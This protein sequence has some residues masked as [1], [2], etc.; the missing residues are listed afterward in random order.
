MLEGDFHPEQIVYGRDI[1]RARPEGMLGEP[2]PIQPRG[3]FPTEGGE[4]IQVGMGSMEGMIEKAKG[5]GYGSQRALKNR[6][7]KE[8]KKLEDYDLVKG[9]DGWRG[10]PKKKD[11]VVDIS[12]YG[13]YGDIA[14]RK[15][16]V[17][18]NIFREYDDVAAVRDTD[19]MLHYR[20]GDVRE[21]PKKKATETTV[22][23]YHGSGMDLRPGEGKTSFTSDRSVAEAYA[24]DRGAI[25]GNVPTLYEAEISFKN[26]KTIRNEDRVGFDWYEKAKAAGHDGVIITEGGKPIEYVVIDPKAVSKTKKIDMKGKKAE[27]ELSVKK[28]DL[29]PD[30][31]I[32]YE[33]EGPGGHYWTD[34]DNGGT[35]ITKEKGLTEVLERR[36]EQAKKMEPLEKGG[37]EGILEQSET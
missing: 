30:N 9:E 8:G 5:G 35:F 28:G 11:K 24:K 32:R 2:P 22:K 1:I 23:V 27:G 12:D 25:E 36:A 21:V 19:G 31:N 20:P 37:A 18:D 6:I 15:K 33:G 26:P 29:I 16:A 3:K 10:V 14:E 4:P 13:T 17:I 34:L 7:K